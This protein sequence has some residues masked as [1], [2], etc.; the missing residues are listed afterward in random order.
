MAAAS[1]IS[2]NRMN[3]FSGIV[4]YVIIWWSV[5]FCMLPIG[6]RQPDQRVAGEMPGAPAKPDLKRKAVWTTLLS[7][8]LW[9][10]VYWFIKSDLF[11][12]RRS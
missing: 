4:V 5:F 3:I 1:L 11:S 7:L 9:G 8:V 6:M 12:F 10:G 2:G